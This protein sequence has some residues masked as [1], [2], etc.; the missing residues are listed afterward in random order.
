MRLQNVVEPASEELWKVH[1][2]Q[3]KED[4]DGIVKVSWCPI[5]SSSV[6]LLGNM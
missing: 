6:R 2:D 4:V 5:L 3:V 1:D